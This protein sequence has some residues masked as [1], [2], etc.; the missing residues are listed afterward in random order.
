MKWVRPFSGP[1]VASRV[2]ACQC[3]RDGHRVSAELDHFY[4]MRTSKRTPTFRKADGA[5][6]LTKV[7]LYGNTRP[8]GLASRYNITLQR[9]S[10]L[11]M[12]NTVHDLCIAPRRFLW[13]GRWKGLWT[14][15]PYHFL[16]RRIFQLINNDLRRMQGRYP[17][18]CTPIL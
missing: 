4:P 13:T 11:P 6:F 17:Q 16:S 1:Y 8:Y 18:C 12:A 10:P 7:S 14:T 5:P 9:D 3:D 15:W 2:C